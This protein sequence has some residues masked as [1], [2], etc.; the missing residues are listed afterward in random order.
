MDVQAP[1]GEPAARHVP[2]ER[3]ATVADVGQVVDRR[4]AR[5][6]R[7]SPRLAQFELADLAAQR[8]KEANHCSKLRQP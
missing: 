1:E 3:L 8:I 4:T 7:Q 5:V 2:H 6:H